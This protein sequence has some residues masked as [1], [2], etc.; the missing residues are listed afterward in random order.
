M[1]FDSVYN[2]GDIEDLIDRKG[3]ISFKEIMDQ[4]PMYSSDGVFAAIQKL[5]EEDRVEKVDT[6]NASRIQYRTP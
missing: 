1:V 5:V 2:R 6:D 3:P 4:T